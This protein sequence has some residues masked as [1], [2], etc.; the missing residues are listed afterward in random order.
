MPQQSNLIYGIRPILE[1]IHSGK[2]IDKVLMVSGLKGDL[3]YQLNDALRLH[4]IPTQ[5]VPIE[6]INRLAPNNNQG[7]VAFISNVVYQSLEAL[8][9][10]AFEAGRVPL[11][12]ILDRITDVRNFGAIVRT[13]VCAGVDAVVIPDKSSAQINEDA[14]KTSAGALLTMPI[15]RETNL[16]TTIHFL[17]ASGLQVVAATEK[18]QTK[19]TDSD[20]RQPIAILIGSEEDGVSKDYLKLCD[21]QMSIPLCG[22]IE[23]LNVSVA[24]GILLYEV[25]RQR[26]SL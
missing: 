3:F 21:S 11:V 10:Q 4:K 17:K 22:V 7:V 24:T 6:K 14:I 5:F 16:K 19:Y 26:D 12:L 9:M 13:A 15:C 1:A 2:E 18:A 23:S 25:R 8:I 20:M